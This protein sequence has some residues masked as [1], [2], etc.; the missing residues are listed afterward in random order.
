MLRYF[1][2]YQEQLRFY[3]FTCSV[4]LNSVLKS[5]SVQMQYQ[6]FNRIVNSNCIQA[7]IVIHLFIHLSVSYYEQKIIILKNLMSFLKCK[8]LI[9]SRIC[10]VALGWFQILNIDFS[11]TSF[12][13]FQ[14]DFLQFSVK[15]SPSLSLHKSNY[16]I[17]DTF[18]SDLR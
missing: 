8:N 6:P 12:Q 7:K 5:C 11:D 2:H 9:M 18:H 3:L 15:K 13:V 1:N 4:F 14:V 10:C 16:G 17:V